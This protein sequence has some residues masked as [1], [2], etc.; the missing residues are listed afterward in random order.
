[1]KRLLGLILSTALL[2]SCNAFP[3][4][5]DWGLNVHLGDDHRF[6]HRRYWHDGH[7]WVDGV[8]VVE[9]A[10][11]VE[12]PRPVVIVPND[13]IPVRFRGVQYYVR[14]NHWYILSDG[15]QLVL[16]VNPTR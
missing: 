1:M 11:V 5:A 4:L 16:V 13:Y 12:Q 3:A 6:D 9:P 14:D 8:V 2:S 10:V 7:W 15:A